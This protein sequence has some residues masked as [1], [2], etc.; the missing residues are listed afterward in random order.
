[1]TNRPF[2]GRACSPRTCADPG[3]PPRRMAAGRGLSAVFSGDGRVA[4]GPAVA[5]IASGH[6]RG[7]LRRHRCGGASHLDGG[8]R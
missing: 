7:V 6:G 3:H 2:A 4:T 1:M 5:A 8:L